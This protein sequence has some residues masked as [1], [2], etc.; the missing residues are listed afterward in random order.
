MQN[1]RDV[2]DHCGFLDLGF[3]G[4]EFTWCGWRRGEMIWERLDQGV[5]K[6]EWLAR[7]PME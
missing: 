7:Y 6:Y 1:F 4:L 2:L 3:L 5:T